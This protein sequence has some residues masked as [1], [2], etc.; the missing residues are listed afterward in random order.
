M[1]ET[2]VSASTC[3]RT[4]KRDVAEQ[5]ESGEMRQ[6]WR[7]GQFVPADVSESRRDDGPHLR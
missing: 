7:D 1:Q 5:T 3:K 6:L 4:C 2:Q